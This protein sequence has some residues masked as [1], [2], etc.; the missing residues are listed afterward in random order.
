MHASQLAEIASLFA[1]ASHSLLA[2]NVVAAGDTAHVYW[3]AHRFRCDAWHQRISSHRSAIENCGTSR[4]TRLWEAIVPALREILISEPLTRVMAYMARGLELR[5]ADSDWGALA[6]GAM[7][8]HLEARHRCLNLMVFGYGLPVEQAVELNRLRRWVEFFSDQLL[9]AVPPLVPVANYAF[10]PQIVAAAQ[11]EFKRYPMAG[12]M[13]AIRLNALN[14]SL[15]SLLTRESR[16]AAENPRMNLS[17]A[18][19][20][21][22]LLPPQ[23]FDSFGVGKGR[24]QESLA[25][26]V[27]DCSAKTNDAAAP[28]AAP[29]S[30]LPSVP[31]RSAPKETRRF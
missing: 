13:P 15:Q 29:F 10:E 7:E 1:S 24:V 21:L 20:A 23:V 17:V 27:V 26:C 16:M 22:A 6:H 2:D 19:A 14:M 31:T 4:R 9:S 3:L 12:A 30:L 18:E 5:G 11:L 25:R 28:L 8:N